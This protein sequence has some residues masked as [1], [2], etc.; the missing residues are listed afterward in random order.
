[1]SGT[2]RQTNES[3]AFGTERAWQQAR[4][5][6]H[7]EAV[8][9][10]E[11]ESAL[12]REG[13]DGFQHRREPCDRAAAEVVAER[14]PARKDDRSSV[15]RKRLRRVPDPRRVGAEP[16]ERELCVAVVVRAREDDHRDDRPRLVH[17]AAASGGSV[18]SSIE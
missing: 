5:G 7:L 8:A 18:C 12:G 4:F 3:D 9:D 2:S 13:N 11:H 14:E 15:G 6:E 1:M 10:P 17:V 16:L